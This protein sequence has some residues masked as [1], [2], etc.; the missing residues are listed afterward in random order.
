MDFFQVMAVRLSI[1]ELTPNTSEAKK[2]EIATVSTLS[3]VFRGEVL[4]IEAVK[5]AM[6]T[7]IV[8]RLR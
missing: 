3:V 2:V 1:A 4:I 5:P 8:V 7:A 6:K